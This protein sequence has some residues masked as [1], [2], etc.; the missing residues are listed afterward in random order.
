MSDIGT[1]SATTIRDHVATELR[2]LLARR[3]MSATELARRI[4]AT[5]P[6]LWRRMSGEISFDLDDLQKIAAVLGVGVSD[7]LPKA[8]SFW[9]SRQPLGE[10]V[11]ATVGEERKPSIRPHRPGR[12]VRQ[13]RPTGQPRPL[14]AVTA[15]R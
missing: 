6:Y 2:V 9:K 7:L 4:G 3:R 12:P 10:R 11:V 13:T 14:T 8:N 15:G 5:Q 1:E